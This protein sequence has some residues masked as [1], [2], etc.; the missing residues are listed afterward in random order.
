M[1]QLKT[2]LAGTIR[3]RRRA[4]CVLIALS[5]VVPAAAQA[6]QNDA[7]VISNLKVGLVCG[8]DDNRRI[9]FQTNDIQITNESTCVYNRRHSACTWYGYSFDYRSPK[10]EIKLQ[11]TFSSSI[12]GSFG[13]PSAE[14]EKDVSDAHYE[15]ALQSRD[16]HFFNPQYAI[17]PARAGGEIESVK[18]SCSYL[19]KT[20]FEFDLRI[21]YP[22]E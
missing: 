16:G 21:H 7:V 2:K 3:G 14:L 9:C 20:V 10:D 6:Q 18:Q 15:I 22:E 8:P 12:R 5:G 17:A 1:A 11:C 13:N 19:G 4:V